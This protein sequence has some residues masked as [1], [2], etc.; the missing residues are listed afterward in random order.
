M[1]RTGQKFLAIAAH[2]D[3]FELFATCTCEL[4]DVTVCVVTKPNDKR[5]NELLCAADIL[6]YEAIFLNL[7]DGFVYTQDIRG[8]IARL[9]AEYRP[10]VVLTHDPWKR[11]Q[12]HPDHRAVGIQTIDAITQA[13]LLCTHIPHEVWLWN[14]D[15]PDLTIP[16]RDLSRKTDAL[17]CY[18][19]QGFDKPQQ[20]SHFDSFKL[21]VPQEVMG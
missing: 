5:Y 9:F 3:D 7:V 17:R 14:T 8:G 16:L 11:W 18:V 1:E 19:S 6:G 10:D 12:L 13:R 15:Y 4:G 21:I 20:V 2:A